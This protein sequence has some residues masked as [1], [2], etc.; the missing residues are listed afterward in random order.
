MTCTDLKYAG[1]DSNCIGGWN[2]PG[3]YTISDSYI[4]SCGY[5]IMFGGAVPSITNMVPQNITIT[6]TTFTKDPAWEAQSWTCKNLLEFKA[7]INVTVTYSTFSNNWK[8]A[9]NTNGTFL[10]LKSVNQNDDAG[11][12][13]GCTWCEV[14]NVLIS[15]IKATNV[16]SGISL[17]DGQGNGST[18]VPM[19]NVTIQQSYIEIDPDVSIYQTTHVAGRALMVLGNLENITIDHM[20]FHH[21]SADYAREIEFDPQ[22]SVVTGFTFTSSLWFDNDLG[23]RGA[24]AT[25]G[26]ATLDAYVPG[27][28]TFDDNLR[29]SANGSGT[30]PAGN[31]VESSLANA[32]WNSTTKLFNAGSTYLTL[33]SEGTAI[34]WDGTGGRP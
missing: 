28:Y 17:T 23:V 20:T 3:P 13:G 22:G 29:I 18:F 33:A 11:T 26:T 31:Y 8:S 5:G 21:L 32:N 25:E 24:G 6:R 30:Y 12:P 9:A 4:Q 7:G 15:H 1:G 16:A 34:G 2:G 14:R 19:S 27:G 10:W